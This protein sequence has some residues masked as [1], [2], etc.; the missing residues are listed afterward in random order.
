M[1]QSISPHIIVCDSSYFHDMIAF[2]I[3]LLHSKDDDCSRQMF[4]IFFF[5]NQYRFANLKFTLVEETLIFITILVQFLVCTQMNQPFC[6]LKRPQHFLKN[7]K[8]KVLYYK[9][10]LACKV[11]SIHIFVNHQGCQL[12]WQNHLDFC[13]HAVY[14]WIRVQLDLVN[15][16]VNLIQNAMADIRE[17]WYVGSGRHRHYP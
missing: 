13:C 6:C 1:S 16:K 7:A 17:T 5:V 14:G 12:P 11:L 3:N 4:Q 15:T 10:Q 8:I 9:I 2:C